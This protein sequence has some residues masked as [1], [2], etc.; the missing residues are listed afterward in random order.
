MSVPWFFRASAGNL[1]TLSPLRSPGTVPVSDPG[2]PSGC[3]AD[4]TLR[5]LSINADRSTSG[6]DGAV[7]LIRTVSPEATSD[8]WGAFRL[9]IA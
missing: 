5:P 2:V 1:S 8:A 3:N 9:V 6:V 7:T 4:V